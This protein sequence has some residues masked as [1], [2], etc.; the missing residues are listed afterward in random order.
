MCRPVSGQLDL[1]DCFLPILALCEEEV[2]L[3]NE[4]HT[5]LRV[6]GL[7]GAYVAWPDDLHMWCRISKTSYRLTSSIT[8]L[9]YQALSLPPVWVWYFK[10]ESSLWR[11]LPFYEY[12]RHGA[13]I[14]IVRSCRMSFDSPC[15]KRNRPLPPISSILKPLKP[16]M[17]MLY[18]YTIVFHRSE[19][20][21]TTV[22]TSS[23]L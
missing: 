6:Y 9:N 2:L 20:C 14:S 12:T 5:V 10:R 17:P 21:R 4:Q 15:D 3:A 16:T 13:G 23:P 18:C 11:S 22:I 7:C 19:F 1:R 8:Q